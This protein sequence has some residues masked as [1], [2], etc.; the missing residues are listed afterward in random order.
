MAR[1]RRRASF[2]SDETIKLDLVVGVEVSAED[3]RDQRVG[4]P[5]LAHPVAV[6][7][8]DHRDPI[9]V[10]VDGATEARKRGTSSSTAVDRVDPKWSRGGHGATSAE[11][12]EAEQRRVDDWTCGRPGACDHGCGDRVPERRPQCSAGDS[13][14]GTATR[15][16]TT[17][18]DEAGDRTPQAGRVWPSATSSDA[19]IFQTPPATLA[20]ANSGTAA[21]ASPKSAPNTASMSGRATTTSRTPRDPV[22]SSVARIEPRSSRP[23]RD[24]AR[25]SGGRPGDAVR[26]DPQ[27]LRQRRGHGVQTDVLQGKERGDDQD[28]DPQHREQHELPQPRRE[29]RTGSR[30]RTLRD[31]AS[32]ARSP[33]VPASPTPTRVRSTGRCRP[34]HRGAP[35][36]PTARPSRAGPQLR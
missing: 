27:N 6:V 28:V 7:G 13:H 20:S 5:V 3:R 30:A 10:V 16:T 8:G 18:A 23:P 9:D 4:F 35:A 31:L 22:H 33:A 11:G 17:I 36:R 12:H 19:T 25:W 32:S 26:D 2:V 24:R 34:R 21:E 15:S 1:F 14:A 29:G